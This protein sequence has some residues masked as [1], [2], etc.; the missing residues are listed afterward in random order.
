MRRQEADLFHERSSIIELLPAH[1]LPEQ[2][3]YAVHPDTGI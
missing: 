3:I 2:G 1:R